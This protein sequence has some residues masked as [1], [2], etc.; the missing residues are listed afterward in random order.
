M[1]I[2]NNGDSIVSG[3]LLQMFDYSQ[4]GKKKK[5]YY[6]TGISCVA[7][8]VLQFVSTA[9]SPRRAWF[10]LLYIPTKFL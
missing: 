8:S 5:I 10:L 6:L 1:N 2:S 9:Y 7:N 3:Q 4:N